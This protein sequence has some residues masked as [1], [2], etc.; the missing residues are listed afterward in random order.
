MY[1]VP[2]LKPLQ[3]EIV[4]ACVCWEILVIHGAKHGVVVHVF[5]HVDDGEFIVYHGGRHCSTEL[6]L[7]NLRER[8]AVQPWASIPC[9]S[10]LTLAWPYSL[11]QVL[12]PLSS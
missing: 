10:E 3:I 12:F 7:A 8:S 11:Y 4:F 9:G 6:D 2:L 1:R 5:K